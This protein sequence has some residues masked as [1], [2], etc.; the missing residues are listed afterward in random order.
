MDAAFVKRCFGIRAM[1]KDD[2]LVNCRHPE[3]V[4]RL[5]K[6]VTIY[7]ALRRRGLPALVGV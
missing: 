5:K 6:L 4:R 3:N 2:Q 1:D 7:S